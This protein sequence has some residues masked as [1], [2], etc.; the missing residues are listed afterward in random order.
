MASDDIAISVQGLGKSYTIAHQNARSASLG[1]AVYAR[2]RRPFHGRQEQETFWALKDVS[3]DVRRGEV[4][5]IIGRNGAGKST[6]LKLLSR[7]TSPTTGAIDIHGRVASLL[8]VGT[9][10]HPELTGREN[11]YLNGAI[12][13]MSRREIGRKFDE[14]V[15]FA[16]VERFLDTPVKRYSSGMGVRL[17]FSVAAHLETEILILDEVLAVGDA[18]YQRRCYQKLSE[19][20]ESGR[21]ILFVSHNL[22][23]IRALCLTAIAL[24]R[25]VVVAHGEA[26]EQVSRYVERITTAHATPMEERADHYGTGSA[27]VTRIEFSGGAGNPVDHVIA[28]DPLNVTVHYRSSKVDVRPVVVLSF[29]SDEGHRLFHVDNGIRGILLDPVKPRGHYLCKIDRLPLAPGRYHVN[30]EIWFGDELA[31]G[32][33]SATAIEVVAGDFYGSGMPTPT[34]GCLMFLDHSWS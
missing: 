34:H 1:E 3:F 29:D 33:A 16:G 27:S 10:F 25:G 28:G 6:L 21:T 20:H 2:A 22:A 18:E 19:I 9:G 30:V 15:A 14:I 7:I 23:S 17:G 13:G 8:E 26:G 11:I 31:D 4:L 24:D 12:L 5:G 32:L